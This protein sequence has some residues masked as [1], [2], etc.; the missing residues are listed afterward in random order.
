MT[1]RHTPNVDLRDIVPQKSSRHGASLGLI[2]VHDTEG[3]NLKGVTDLRNLGTVFRAR[4]VSAHVGADDEGNSARYVP[5][6]LKAW[7]CAYYN[8]W[9]LG[10]ELIGKATQPHWTDAQVRECARWVAYWCHHHS[11][12]CRKGAVS[13]DGRILRRGVVRH[14]DLGNLGG[15]HTDP[16]TFPLAACLVH[17]R[18]YLKA[19]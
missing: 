17:A 4:D 18:R 19:Y 16:G 13:R 8:P 7:H 5:D 12:P 3:A 14:S 2:T 6:E 15:G 9:S 11:I 1:E 10:I